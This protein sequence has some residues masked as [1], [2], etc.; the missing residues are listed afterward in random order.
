MTPH[1]VIHFWFD[2][3][4]ESRWFNSD[5][6]LDAEI[7]R[8]FAETYEAA[9]DGKLAPWENSAEGAVAL[10]ILLD[11]FPRN[12]FRNRAEAFATDAQA[13]EIAI[14]AI[15]GGFDLEAPVR[16]G[17]S[18]ICHSCIPSIWSTRIVVFR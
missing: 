14:S 9:R 8:R 2:E 3:V 1:Y 13:R 11:Q 18:S 4:G 16:C 12:M 7:R 15:A 6:A 17:R 10:L 5:A